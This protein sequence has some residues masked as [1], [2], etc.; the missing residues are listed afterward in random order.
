MFS[1]FNIVLSLGEK[2]KPVQ[3]S[4]HLCFLLTSCIYRNLSQSCLCMY[5]ETGR[6]KKLLITDSC[7]DIYDTGSVGHKL[8][9]HPVL[10]LTYMAKQA[11]T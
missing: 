6:V 1:S 10:S 9:C 2:T 11:E 5:M 4:K 8:L 3:P 7:Q